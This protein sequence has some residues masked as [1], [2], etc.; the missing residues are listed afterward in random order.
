MY[1]A[2]GTIELQMN[3]QRV[4][5]KYTQRQVQVQTWLKSK[6]GGVHA[7]GS[8]D[9]NNAPPADA[10]D[11]GLSSRPHEICRSWVMPGLPLGTVI[12][13]VAIIFLEIQISKTVTSKF[14]VTFVAVLSREGPRARCARC[15]RCAGLVGRTVRRG[16]SRVGLRGGVRKV[17]ES[18]RF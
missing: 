7:L 14:C 1:F 10:R 5:S 11:S 15:A 12:E 3:H 6:R 4:H 13:I 2:A 17:A 18:G 8:S 9:S 16:S